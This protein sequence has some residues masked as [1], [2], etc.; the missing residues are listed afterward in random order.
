[1]PR[2]IDPGDQAAIEP[3][4]LVDMLAASRIDVRDEDAF[5]ALGPSLA[6]LGRNRSF[7]AD[8]AIDAL[9]QRRDD[10]ARARGYGPQVLIL[11]PPDGR[12]LVRANFW[13]ARGDAVFRASGPRTF[14]YDLPHDHN[15]PF[16]TV[17]Y[18]GPGYWSDY[19]EYDAQQVTGVPGSPAGLRYIERSRLE[20]GRLMLYRMRRDVHVQLPPDAF[21]VSLN[22][23]GQD[24]EQ[25]WIDQY[26]FDIAGNRIEA[27]LATT[28]SEVLL[29]IAAQMDGNGRD[30]AERFAFSHASARMR[31]TAVRALVAAE[32][33]GEAAGR[34]LDRATADPDAL[35]AQNA[36]RDLEMLHDKLRNGGGSAGAA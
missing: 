30:L 11:H 26:R 7:L 8:A 27:G 32:A 5:A 15:F 3:A 31:L 22:I 20:E 28:A 12:F 16:L 21:S 35:V 29:T 36:C 18:L 6:R 34:W 25:P 24:P 33:D 17:G 1:M 19:F 14:F 13:P 10:A 23:L 2:L 9:K 4:E